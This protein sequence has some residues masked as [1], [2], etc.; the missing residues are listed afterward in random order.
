[1]RKGIFTSNHSHCSKIRE[2]EEREKGGGGGGRRGEGEH[3]SNSIS[4]LSS[5]VRNTSPI[6]I[7]IYI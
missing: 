3:C 7:Y 2:R 6:Y 4:K 5:L 1:M